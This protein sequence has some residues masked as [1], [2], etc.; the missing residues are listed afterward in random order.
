[1]NFNEILVK[2]LT[3]QE[4]TSEERAILIAN[5]S[6]LMDVADEVTAAKS[7]E[8]K[9]K[10]AKE[11]FNLFFTELKNQT[12][13]SMPEFM[14]YV[15]N[16]APKTRKG[17]K[18]CPTE[19]TVYDTLDVALKAPKGYANAIATALSTQS[20]QSEADLCKEVE[21]LLPDNNKKYTLSRVRYHAKH[22]LPF[23]TVTNGSYALK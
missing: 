22:Q 6:K 4:L 10:E 7:A 17:D 19:V 18:G 8:Q 13:D 16:H 2:K 5:A 12:F 1:M 21:A 14:A 20:P 15:K 9:A 11:A 23:V 3:G